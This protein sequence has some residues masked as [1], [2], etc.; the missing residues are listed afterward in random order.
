MIDVGAARQEVAH[1]L[2]PIRLASA[3][4]LYREA[5]ANDAR[6]FLLDSA[7]GPAELSRFTFVGADPRVVFRAKRAAATSA[8]PRRA[9]CEITREGARAEVLEERD[10]LEVLDALLEEVRVP[11]EALASSPFPFRAGAVGYLGYEAGHFVERLPDEG[12]DDLSF[13]DLDFAFY[14]AVLA[15]D[16]ATGESFVS[17]VGRGATRAEANAHALARATRLRTQIARF[18]GD[19]AASFAWPDRPPPVDAT[20]TERARYEARVVRALEHIAAGD[21]FELCLTHRIEVPYRGS[22][23]ALYRALRE[24]NPAPFAAM[25]T[26]PEGD[27]VASSPERFLRVDGARRAESRPIKGTRPRGATPEEDAH[28]AAELASSPKDQ[29]EHNMIVD[30]VRSDL[31]RVCRF[32]SV[33]VPELRAV[34]PYANV[35]QMVSTITGELGEEARAVDLVRACFPGGS[36]TGAPKIEAMKI[37]DGLEPVKRGIY[38]GAM[39]YFDVAG[40]LDLA[41][42]IRS[43]VLSGGRAT[44]GVGGAIVA[45]STPSGEYDETLHKARALT[46]A[47]SRAAGVT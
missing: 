22:P 31:G 37:I 25:L 17:A 38:S 27:L 29:A 39:G 13:P 28:L 23:W 8:G 36:M 11:E 16:H 20:V 40:G 21:V 24:E 1:V 15:H 7:G 41:M 19:E 35:H 5:F 43:V 33:A 4:F 44:F 26:F 18:E 46:R 9:R 32:G 34:V 2:E 10:P 47:V 14:D 3:P 42:V 30:L 45:D 6:P 12:T